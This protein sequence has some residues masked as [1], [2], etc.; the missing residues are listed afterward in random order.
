MILYMDS[1]D[2]FK[3]YVEEPDSPRVDTNV[4]LADRFASSHLAYA[5]MRAAL[6][7]AFRGNRIARSGR[8]ITDPDYRSIVSAF[9]SAWRAFI[10]I[11][12]SNPILRSAGQL[13]ERH[14]LSGGDAIHLSSVLRLRD[15]VPEE[16][17]VSVADGR[18][19]TGAIA[20][21]LVVI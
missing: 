3:L 16:V 2:I 4:G 13:A 15:V 8:V 21:G 7:A 18:V 20:E 10:K 14:S 6:A 19:K 11:R 12:I 17:R 5:E 1:S 9:E